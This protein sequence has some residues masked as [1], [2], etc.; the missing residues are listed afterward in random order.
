MTRDLRSFLQLLESRGQLRRIDA[1]VDGELEITEITERMLR[2]GGPALL[3]ER[4]KGSPFPIA[5]NVMGTVQR[6][7]LS[8]GME[9]QQELEDLGTKLGKL[10]KPKPPKGIQEAVEFASILFDVVKAKPG[11]ML[12]NAPCQEVVLT[13]DQ[14]DLNLIPMMRPWPKDAGRNLTLGLVMTKDPEDGTPNVGIYRLQQ[15]SKNTM[16]VHW[17]SVR[18]G[19]RHL[20]KAAQM[21]KKLDIAVAVGVDPLLI[22]AAATPIPVELSEWLFAGLYAGE[23][24]KLTRCK[25]SDLLVP[26]HAEF[27]LEGTITPGEIAVDGPF[28]D[29]MGYYGLEEESPLVRFHTLTHR[30]NPIYMT[31]YSGRPPKEE[32]MMAIALNRIYTPLLR[33]QVPEIKD[34]FLPMDALSYKMAVISI[35][36]AYPGQARRAAMAF[37]TALV[38]FTYTKFVVVVDKDI[39]I[40]DPAQVLWAISSKVDPERDVFIIPDTPFDSLDFACPKIGIGSRMGIDATTKIPPET[41]HA[42]GEPLAMDED[43]KNLVS[44]RWAEYGLSDIKL[45]EVDARAWG[46]FG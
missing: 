17:L 37:W 32:A 30:K 36:K 9:S 45:D 7:V 14:V 20:R 38:Q 28:G 24:V 12:L 10:Q 25:G 1:L 26:A 13:Q 33:Q 40:R 3:F 18:G 46:Y 34:F 43:V 42:W 23:G 11:R 2:C 31:T 29:H 6:V 41:D 16:T 8:M 15:Q 4:V 22:M 44:R 21:G 39:N 27:I 35:D 19:A 5:V